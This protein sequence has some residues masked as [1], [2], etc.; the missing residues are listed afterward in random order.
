MKRM[1]CCMRVLTPMLVGRT[2]ISP[3][4][5]TVPAYTDDPVQRMT[6]RGSPVMEDSLTTAVPDITTPSTG[7]AVPARTMTWSPSAISW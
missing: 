7:T 6:P 2:K 5:T 4:S 3:V 1:I